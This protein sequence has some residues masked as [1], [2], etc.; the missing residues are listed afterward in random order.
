MKCSILFPGK[1]FYSIIKD[2]LKKATEIY[3]LMALINKKGIDVIY[4]DLKKVKEKKGRK[5]Y[6]IFGINIHNASLPDAIQKLFELHD[7]NNFNLLLYNGD[8][9]FH[10]KM[11]LF[12]YKNTG[13]LILG[14]SNLTQEG[15][16]SNVEVNCIINDKLQ[17]FS[18][19]GLLRFIDEIKEDSDVITKRWI[20]DY[21]ENYEKDKNLE[22][23]F[24]NKKSRAIKK[25]MKKLTI[26]SKKRE[27]LIKALKAF[28]GTEDYKERKQELP[29]KI[30]EC[31]EAIGKANNPKVK[32]ENW[33]NKELGM[34][35]G[36]DERIFYKTIPQT[37]AKQNKLNK[38]LKILLNE[39]ESI[40]KRLYKVLNG[41][42]YHMEG[43]GISLLS[44][45]LL[46][47]YPEKYP[48]F[49]K[50][51]IETLKKYGIHSFSGDDVKKYLDLMDIYAELR[52]K[53]KY[54][55]KAGYALIDRFMWE[56]GRKILS[57]KSKK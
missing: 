37:K 48:L 21:R 39:K 49:N 26:D 36:I 38:L 31:K 10:P 29:D 52:E 2:N 18:N 45:I 17:K 30:D 51:V 54:P 13:T 16:T 46:K 6:F 23:N 24:F 20:D 11:F 42:K 8:K 4:E 19:D 22:S 43:A 44:D 25:M 50:P 1:K 32:V 34:F 47:Y 33:K 56:E 57:E 5:I 35:S 40:E 15:L 28:K 7:G 55:K 14:S 12:K 41:G 9:F 53:A 3:I 27:N